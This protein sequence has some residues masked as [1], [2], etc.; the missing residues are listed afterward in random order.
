MHKI[1]EFSNNWPSDEKFNIIF[2]LEIIE[3]IIDTDDFLEKCKN[4]SEK[5]VLSFS[6]LPTLLH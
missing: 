1:V 2:A 3:H 5:I 6:Q 4:I